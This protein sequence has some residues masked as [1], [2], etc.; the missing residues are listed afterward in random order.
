MRRRNIVGVGDLDTVK[1]P[2]LDSPGERTL[3]VSSLEAGEA[4]HRRE[5]VRASYC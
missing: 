5:V 3:E 1:S 4:H 2:T